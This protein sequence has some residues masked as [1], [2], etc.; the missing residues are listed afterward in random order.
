MTVPSAELLDSLKAKLP[1]AWYI[2]AVS[3]AATAF[4]G[5]L[6]LEPYYKA[7][8]STACGKGQLWLP[9]IYKHAVSSM[10]PPPSKRTP[11][12]VNFED[13]PLPRRR[14][15]RRIKE[16]LTKLAILIGVPRCIEAGFAFDPVVAEGDRDDAFVR[17]GFQLDKENEERGL[18]LIVDT[19]SYY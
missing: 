16:T 8:T 10:E 15:V 17:H 6:T 19:Q 13:D 14:V 4:P 12:P 2:V 3:V 9:A 1:E 18:Y 5:T 11:S 7:A